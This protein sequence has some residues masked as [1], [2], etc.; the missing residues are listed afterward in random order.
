MLTAL[1]LVIH[2]F[3]I[4]INAYLRITFGFLTVGVCALFYGPFLSGLGCAV[5]DVLKFF[6]RNDGG[7]FFIGFTANEFVSGFLYGL[8]LY[9]KPVTLA[10]TF[11]ARLSA[12]LIV[13]LL[14]NPLCLSLLYGDAFLALVSMRLLK[15]LIMLPIETLMLYTLLKK[16]VAFRPLRS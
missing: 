5:A 2:S 12:M 7:G 11:V 3:T 4:F 8:I 1:N 9:K 16:I 14:L 6:I 10:R 13:S 15:N